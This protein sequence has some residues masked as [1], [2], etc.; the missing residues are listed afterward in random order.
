M[1]G[2]PVNLTYKGNSTF[3]TSWGA[4]VTILIVTAFIWALI[5]IAH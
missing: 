5:G 4:C 3:K 1:F 2:Y